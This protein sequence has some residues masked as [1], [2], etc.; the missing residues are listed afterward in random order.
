MTF[1]HPVKV[2]IEHIT[3]S[4]PGMGLDSWMPR[5]KKERQTLT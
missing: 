1:I 3:Y 2:I 4:M 5:L